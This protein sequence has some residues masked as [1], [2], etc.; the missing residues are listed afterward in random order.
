[1][2]IEKKEITCLCVIDNGKL[3]SIQSPANFSFSILN[4][5][6][7]SNEKMLIGQIIEC[8]WDE[9]IKLWIPIQIRYDKDIPNNLYTYQQTI[10]SIN[11]NI[12]PV[13]IFS[14][15]NISAN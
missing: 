10:K 9:K 4:K 7:V 2:N 11:E 1:M 13:E 3:F 6:G 14:L 15:F 8:L 5:F 12:S